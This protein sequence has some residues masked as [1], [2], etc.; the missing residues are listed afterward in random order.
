MFFQILQFGIDV[1]FFWFQGYESVII[2]GGYSKVD[3]G[4]VMGEEIY[5]YF[6][7]YFYDIYFVIVFVCYVSCFFV[8]CELYI[9]DCIC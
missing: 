1:F 9:C 7:F 8:L 2:V 3:N 5:Y 6:G 4:V